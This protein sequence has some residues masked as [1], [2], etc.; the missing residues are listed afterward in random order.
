MLT[1]NNLVTTLQNFANSHEIL[2]SFYFN[3]PWDEQS[4]GQSIRYPMMFATLQPSLISENIDKTVFKIYITDRVKKG[5]RNEVEVLSDTK[6]IAKDVLVYL[7]LTSFTEIIVVKK[8][9]T[10]NHFTE[11]FDDEV[12]GCWFELEIKTKF[13]WNICSVPVV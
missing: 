10:L 3:D 7:S 6:L 1:L 13:D 5:E 12:A 11:S 4:G 8:D 2:K 9:T